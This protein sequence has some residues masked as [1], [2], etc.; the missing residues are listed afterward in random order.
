MA[1]AQTGSGPESTKK[2]PASIPPPDT[3]WSSRVQCYRLGGVL[4][5]FGNDPLPHPTLPSLA[6]S[7]TLARKKVKSVGLLDVQASF[8]NSQGNHFLKIGLPALVG[9]GADPQGSRVA[10]SEEAVVF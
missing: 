5:H 6:V 1:C 10:G 3:S 7:S 2:K 4:P 9:H 8:D